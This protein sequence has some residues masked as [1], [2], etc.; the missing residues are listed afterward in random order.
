M[1]FTESVIMTRTSIRSFTGE[2]VPRET[3]LK[4]A[5]AGTAAPSAMNVQPWELI[6]VTDRKKLDTLCGALP[7]AK[8]L[9]KA[10]A[11]FIV[12]GDPQKK[13][14]AAKR[15]WTED[16]AAVTE[17]IL[18]AVH[19]LGLGA[20]WTAVYPDE[21]RL[22]PVR[23][24]LNIPAEIVPLNVIPVGVIAGKAPAPKDKFNPAVIHYD[25]W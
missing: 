2:A 21:N 23:T 15:H 22:T 3:L 6:I 10:A 8:M 5:R 13:E 20:V 9:D 18:L 14:Q 19:A 17:N 16:C 11:A 1:D 25:G 12:C 4:I 7:N 24:I